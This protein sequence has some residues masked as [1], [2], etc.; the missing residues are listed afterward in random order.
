MT[1]SIITI[2]YNNKSGLESTI[3]SVLSQSCND[4]EYIIID[5]GSTD[6]SI[7]VIQ[8]YA[9]HITYWVS[10]P[11]NGIYH[12]MNKGVA[13]AKGDY[14]SF[15]NSGDCFYDKDVL[16]N[17]KQQVGYDIIEGKVY[18]ISTRQ[19]S[20]KSTDKPTMMFFYRGGLG[21]QACLIRS[22]LLRDEPY[23]E[24]LRF[25]ADWKFFVKKIIFDNCSYHFV[26]LP[27]VS[28]EGNGTST[29]N[30]SCYEA[31]RQQTLEQFFPP[32]ILADYERFHDKESPMI[33]LIPYFNKTSGLQKVILSFTK[34]LIHLYQLI[35]W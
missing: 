13:Q 3:K 27:V 20:Y 24:C 2:N 4:Y 11:D 9:D 23:D 17:L 10:E 25:A 28:F 12:A 33:D 15:M 32:R 18:D 22:Q 21:H 26:N 35:K 30:I 14:L 31:E 34:S 1:Y 8:Q 29:K 5:G 16:L 7:E 6:G 19:F